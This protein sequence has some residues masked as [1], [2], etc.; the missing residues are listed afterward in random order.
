MQTKKHRD[1]WCFF[2]QSMPNVGM[3][4]GIRAKAEKEY[5]P[6]KASIN[7]GEETNW[8]SAAPEPGSKV[9]FFEQPL[10]LHALAAVN[11]TIKKAITWTDFGDARCTNAFAQ[12]PPGLCE[13]C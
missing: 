2:V 12:H 9:I 3:F 10:S 4:W 13:I 11:K 5:L 8:S 6:E 7:R 1:K